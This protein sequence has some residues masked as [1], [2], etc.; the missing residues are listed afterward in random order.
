MQVTSGLELLNLTFLCTKKIH[1]VEEL[2][3]SSQV[4][5]VGAMKG[6]KE[7]KFF[8]FVLGTDLAT[9]IEN[10]NFFPLSCAILYIKIKKNQEHK[11]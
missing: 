6:K 7:K 10:V 2:V 3:K 8:S 4:C 1:H 9:R 11:K 5:R